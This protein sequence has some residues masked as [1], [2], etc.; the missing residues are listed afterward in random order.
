[1]GETEKQGSGPAVGRPKK[2]AID[3]CGAIHLLPSKL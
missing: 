2:A 1:M 3:P